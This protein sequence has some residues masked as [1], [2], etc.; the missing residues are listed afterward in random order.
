MEE[1]GKGSVRV[2]RTLKSNAHLHD[3]VIHYMRTR[4]TG[5]KKESSTPL[6]VPQSWASVN[7]LR[8]TS[9]TSILVSGET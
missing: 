3:K 8:T 1:N 5:E 4:S 9:G 2:L 7:L 6:M